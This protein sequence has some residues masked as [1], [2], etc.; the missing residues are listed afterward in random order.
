MREVAYRKI[1]KDSVADGEPESLKVR[2]SEKICE[3]ESFTHM[4]DFG[5]LALATL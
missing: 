5:L 3:P 1:A 4:R 2:H